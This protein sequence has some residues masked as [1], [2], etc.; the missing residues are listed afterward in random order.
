MLRNRVT[1]GERTMARSHGSLKRSLS[2]GAG[3]SLSATVRIAEAG[4]PLTRFTATVIS[5]L[6]VCTETACIT[7]TRGAAGLGTAASGVGS[8]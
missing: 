6:P 8:A 1:L 5:L 7:V 3:V 2:A 4:R